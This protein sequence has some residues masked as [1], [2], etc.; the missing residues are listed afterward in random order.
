ML[1]QFL[2]CNTSDGVLGALVTHRCSS[3]TC[4]VLPSVTV[5]ILNTNKCIT[6]VYMSVILQMFAFFFAVG[7]LSF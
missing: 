2:E 7:M 3:V 4:H 1:E 6:V 5:F